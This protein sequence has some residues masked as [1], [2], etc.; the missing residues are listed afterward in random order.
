MSRHMW[1]RILFH[2]DQIIRQH[3]IVAN[4]TKMIAKLKRKFTH[5][6]REFIHRKSK[7]MV[8][9]LRCYAVPG[10]IEVTLS[11]LDYLLG[12][13]N[14]TANT[15]LNL[16]GGTGQD[17]GLLE[18]IGFDVFNLNIEMDVPS[19]KNIRFDLNM[20]NNLPFDQ[21][22]FDFVLCQEVIEHIE[23][24]WQLFRMI[25]K[26]LKIDGYAVL[27]TPNVQS[28]FST[29]VFVKTGYFHWFRP[30]CFL[31]HVNALPM[32]EIRL[33]AERT[34]FEIEKIRGNGDYYFARNSEK[35]L[36]EVVRNNECL[37][38][39]LR[40]NKSCHLK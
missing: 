36:T 37:I 31:Y 34:G 29:Q 35:R 22:S 27:T 1:L 16:G 10:T 8:D 25:N 11:E 33:I 6:E 38:F 7:Y 32:W 14:S 19:K 4:D 26:I 23:N 21:D 15:L 9:C 28:E 3:R 18:E 20:G 39:V 17:A 12:A 30:D 13:D 24:P 2:W 40:K 5:S